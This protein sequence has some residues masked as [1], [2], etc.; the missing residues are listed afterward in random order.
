MRTIP[1]TVACA[2][3]GAALAGSL[4]LYRTL[5]LGRGD[6]QP[7]VLENLNPAGELL[8]PEGIQSDAQGN[9]YVGDTQSRVWR[10]EGGRA[11][12][13]V[14]LS[15]VQATANVEG[16]IH[17]GGLA[18][19]ARGTLYVAAYGF[20]EG[21]VLQVEAG[22]RQ[23]RFFARGIGV[24][25]SL[26]V[27][28]DSKYLWVSDFHARGRVLRFPVD[29]SL[30]ASPDVVVSGLE[31]PNGLALGKDER[32][33]FAAETYAGTVARLDLASHAPEVTRVVNLKGSFALGSLDGLAF[34]PRD[35]NRRFLYVAENIRGMFTVVDLEA[36]PARVLKRLRLALMGGRPC[37]ASM[38]IREGYV[39]FTDL[40]ACSPVR[41]L[42]GI[43]KWRS[44][45]YRFRVTDLSSVY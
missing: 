9:L 1:K 31:Y 44:H 20:A 42:L 29:S 28:Q 37:P 18:F 26:V 22:T 5:E 8:G 24:A 2:S 19:D 10:L 45:A 41:I 43:P 13:Y 12:P 25:N 6:A 27:T 30:P 32:A 39:F 36:R 14:D 4:F 34:D 23:V 33:L 11:V 21:S 35:R 3:L 7:V 17:A 15:Q 16:S 38:V 40:W